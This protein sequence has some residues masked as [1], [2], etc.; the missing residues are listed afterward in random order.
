MPASD[1]ELL[2]LRFLGLVDAD[3][4]A[5]VADEAIDTLGSWL[6]ADSSSAR[7]SELA[8]RYLARRSAERGI[9]E[10]SGSIVAG[11][12]DPAAGELS[13]SSVAVDGTQT[14]LSSVPVNARGE[15]AVALPSA[16]AG[17]IAL[18]RARAAAAET[19]AMVTSTPKLTWLAAATDGK[20]RR[21]RFEVQQTWLLDALRSS[22]TFAAASPEAFA[23]RDPE[24]LAAAS[25]LSPDAVRLHQRAVKVGQRLRVDDGLA[26]AVLRSLGLGAHREDPGE[27]EAVFERWLVMVP[28]TTLEQLLAAAVELGAVSAAREAGF[29]AVLAAQS[30]LR[31]DVWLG[32]PAGAA[33]RRSSSW[34]EVIEAAGVQGAQLDADRSLFEVP[35]DAI[36]SELRQRAWLTP[37]TR[38]LLD[39]AELVDFHHGAIEKLKAD[40]IAEPGTAMRRESPDDIAARF[41]HLGDHV[42]RTARQAL[43]TRFPGHTLLWQSR[44]A[45]D[46]AAE[47]FSRG[48]LDLDRLT[49]ALWKG[50]RRDDHI[51]AVRGET[52]SVPKVSDE[53]HDH[54]MHLQRLLRIGG[55]TRTSLALHRAGYDSANQ[56]A[57]TSFRT[58]RQDME[59]QGVTADEARDLMLTARSRSHAAASLHAETNA[60][61]AGGLRTTPAP[62]PRFDAESVVSRIPTLAT[63]FGSLDSCEC[64]ACES[65]VSPAA[66]LVDL[67]LWLSRADFTTGN[68][69]EVLVGKTGVPGRRPDLAQTLLNCANTEIQVPHIDL[70][71]ELLESQIAKTLDPHAAIPA[72]QT[73]LSTIEQRAYPEHLN[74]KV[75]AQLAKPATDIPGYWPFSLFLEEIRGYLTARRTTRLEVMRAY[76]QGD[77]ELSAEVAGLSSEQVNV[78]TKPRPT[79]QKQI[80]GANPA[81]LTVEA[82]LQR[83]SAFLGG[84]L[85]YDA[86]ADLLACGFIAG[87][88]T[89]KLKLAS[90][91]G[92]VDSCRANE[93]VV[94][95]LDADVLDR[96][97][98]LLR[99]SSAAKADPGQLAR[100]V[101]VIEVKSTL[102]AA[103]LARV[104]TMLDLARELGVDLVDAATF[105]G[106]FDT[107]VGSAG[108]RRYRDVFTVRGLFPTGTIDGAIASLAAALGLT[109]ADARAVLTHLGVPGSAAIDPDKLA[110]LYRHA[111][112]AATLG[113][114]V[115]DY[116]ASFAQL[117]DPFAPLLPARI[118][119]FARAH[120]RWTAAH[121]DRAVVERLTIA[122]APV[123]YAPLWETFQKL[124]RRNP[125]GGPRQLLDDGLWREALS[126]WIMLTDGA[127]LDIVGNRF[128]AE[129][130]TI[131]AWA[132]KGDLAQPMPPVVA[133]DLDEAKS[134]AVLVR[135]GTLVRTSGLAAAGNP[136]FEDLARKADVASF[137]R[138]LAYGL[139]GIGVLK[140]A[141]ALLASAPGAVDVAAL[142]KALDLPSEVAGQLVTG[143]SATDP[144]EGWLQVA[145]RLRLTRLTALPPDVLFGAVAVAPQ[146]DSDR[147]TPAQKLRQAYQRLGSRD[148][149]LS[150]SSQVQDRLRPR[151]RDALV[152]YLQHTQGLTADLLSDQLLIEVSTAEC[153]DRSRIEEACSAIQ[154]FVNR[155]LLGA[156]AGL[157]PDQNDGKE[158]DQ[159][160]WRKRYSTWKGNRLVFLY[161]ESYMSTGK[162]GTATALYKSYEESINR[163]AITLTNVSEATIAYLRGLTDIADLEYLAVGSDY[164]IVDDSRP[165]GTPAVRSFSCLAR[166][167]GTSGR[168]FFSQLRG[169]SW[170][171]FEEVAL[172]EDPNHVALRTDGAKSFVVWPRSTVY[173][174]P[175]AKIPD[176]KGTPAETV[177]SVKFG[178]MERNAGGDWVSPRMT[179][180]A[181]LFAGGSLTERQ[182]VLQ[183][184]RAEGDL[185]PGES[186][187][188]MHYRRGNEDVRH[189]GLVSTMTF[190]RDTTHKAYY[191]YANNDVSVAGVAGSTSPD[192]W[193]GAAPA[194]ELIEQHAAA[195]KIDGV[196]D[197]DGAIP[198]DPWK[199]L[200]FD[201]GRM[202]GNA[203]TGV[204]SPSGDVLLMVSP[205]AFSVTV[206]P[207]R[208]IPG[209]PAPSRWYPSPWAFFV[210][211]AS[212]SLFFVEKDTWPS[213]VATS[214]SNPSGQK[215]VK[216]LLGLGA[217]VFNDQQPF[218]AVPGYHPYAFALLSLVKEKDVTALYTRAVQRRP[219]QLF[220]PITGSD[221]SKRARRFKDDLGIDTTKVFVPSNVENVP[222]VEEAIFFTG[223]APH[224]AYNWE[225]FFHAPLQIA[226]QLRARGQYEESRQFFH[227]IFNPIE[228]HVA[229]GDGAPWW[230]TAAFDDVQDAKT[231]LEQILIEGLSNN[232]FAGVEAVPYDAHKVAVTRPA[233]Y[234]RYTVIQYVTTLFDW[235]DSIFRRGGI[236][237]VDEAAQLYRLAGKIL[238][239]RPRRIPPLTSRPDKAFES[240]DKWKG[241]GN[242]GIENLISAGPA[243]PSV[244]DVVHLPLVRVDA[245]NPTSRLFFTVPP[246]S[247]LDVLFDRLDASLRNVWTCSA[248][249]EGVRD[250]ADIQ[251][252][253]DAAAAGG[254]RLRQ[255]LSPGGQPQSRVRF[256]LLIAKAL[257]LCGDARA[258]A[259]SL[260]AAGET[261]DGEAYAAL[262]STWEGRV[263]DTT[264]AILES[265]QR[266]A[267]RDRDA[268]VAARAVAEQRYVFYR[269]RARMSDLEATAF[270]LNIAAAV[271]A[272]VATALDVA[273]APAT[274]VP[275]FTVGAAGIMGSPVGTVTIGGDNIGGGLSA[276]ARAISSV[277][278]LIDRT[279]S[280]VLTQAGYDRRTEDWNEAR[281]EANL[282]I[283]QLDKQLLAVEV[284]VATARKEL[285]NLEQQTSAWEA[286]DEFLTSKFSNADLFLWLVERTTDLY[287]RA[288]EM[289]MEVA[290]RAY[291]ACVFERPSARPPSLPALAWDGSKRGLLAA[292]ELMFS[293]RQ[294][295]TFYLETPPFQLIVNRRLCL[296]DLDSTALLGL[297]YGASCTFMIP[298]WWLRRLD[299]GNTENRRIRS[300]AVTIPCVGG[301]A[302]SVNAMLSLTT[303]TVPIMKAMLGSGVRDYGWDMALRDDAYVPFEGASL[304]DDTTWSLEFP[305]RNADIDLS[306]IADVVL[307]VEYTAD[308]GSAGAT[309]PTADWPIAIDLERDDGLAWQGLVRSAEHVGQIDALRFLPS[310]L[311]HNTTL[312]AASVSVYYHGVKNPL[313]DVLAATSSGTT[314]SLGVKPGAQPKWGEVERVKVE[315]TVAKDEVP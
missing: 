52:E 181:S 146:G 174:R 64:P 293:L 246:S 261:G 110:G 301:P 275:S 150:A 179:S 216:Q 309:G 176:S 98:R 33:E 133:P 18:S 115:P 54:L 251:A 151:R 84:P 213:T 298:G 137:V 1:L 223:I 295:E 307:E 184:T 109:V 193:S 286:Q 74:A 120:R 40:R 94:D 198:I 111:R 107:R 266:E 299:N 83:G 282:E 42:V 2:E 281:E 91:T 201:R 300:V 159:W 142:A 90:S 187:V 113:L 108:L 259:L 106:A 237:N 36:W 41:A 291:T 279:S 190:R 170:D 227:Y 240:A 139:A 145:E 73:T 17:V 214:A 39:W 242:V 100:L 80:W 75:Y 81:D 177:L 10:P 212:W 59:R 256:R 285:S 154:T 37:E 34:R 260:Q 112:L 60:A 88:K 5:V 245:A 244:G 194:D 67:L 283:Q 226:L 117:T 161:P 93:R 302:A 46:G 200:R 116:L 168:Y 280:M 267:E 228:G 169:G 6:S 9:A 144:A 191:Q 188:I 158:W 104:A 79:D 165:V 289:T 48:L 99:L 44:P 29:A 171:G 149:W 268:L 232:P 89:L 138:Y 152:A 13:I 206:L 202:T 55:T 57:L 125:S 31:K 124:R 172:G 126:Q 97:H 235:G 28:R 77:D 315:W 239:D 132:R 243:T 263:L 71:C 238:G 215:K 85:S 11:V 164:R 53:A 166:T 153:R 78:A 62:R 272:G 24:L 121:V 234:Q 122:D 162:R 218:S 308:F 236:E 257:E 303:G 21:R 185:V 173:P 3:A 82:L 65:V 288:M 305:A 196:D 287:M 19:L 278:G 209:A 297:R 51:S 248:A 195:E 12:T 247:E 312:G 118:L 32:A 314:I 310:V 156:E 205:S 129:L 47:L 101:E 70:V 50:A 219:G 294:L 252:L 143:L 222:T 225:L 220:D 87:T 208:S 262:R 96:L 76:G 207:W 92:G 15:F 306:T 296:R 273:S 233:A 160:F 147:A 250:D 72:Y 210:S 45:L 27:W 175:N 230:I 313:T 311:A 167:R 304:D 157:E 7:G 20:Q 224:Q 270:G 135:V 204:K 102:S 178:W 276:A 258:L 221:G 86:L 192:K 58:F 16:R 264:K 148:E 163:G 105:L 66:Y 134:L 254:T 130:V 69:Y 56:I 103:T 274:A 183:I 23:G 217:K 25:G 141:A 68:A 211:G 131:T 8:R 14:P 63:L 241:G 265:R 277:T 26:W 199:N 123:D 30:A 284:R 155:V 114:S 189:S 271:S 43:E 292:D 269:D 255:A 231:S 35:L 128:A 186:K 119:A 4:S 95:Q 22:A 180:G 182:L 140:P 49:L 38:A 136:A 61:V 253:A 203:G 249:T 229:A 290:Q 127:D 197:N